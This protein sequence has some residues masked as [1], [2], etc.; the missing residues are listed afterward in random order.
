MWSDPAPAAKPRLL[1]V[2]DV[3]GYR[4]VLA[5]ELGALG[6]DVVAFPLAMEA[7]NHLDCDPDIKLAVLDIRMPTNT[8][9][10][11]ALARMMLYRDRGVRVILM[12]GYAGF[13]DIPETESFGKVLQ[14][15]D[16]IPALALAIHE[17]LAAP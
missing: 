13:I 14:K 6:Y 10:G 5:R 12:T 7:L 8:L 1:L 16:N 4:Y 3:D 9:T 17:R 15:T 11:L 2:E